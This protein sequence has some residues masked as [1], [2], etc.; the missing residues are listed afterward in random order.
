MV[1]PRAR[2]T[3]G[4]PYKSVRRALECL[5]R[6]GSGDL[7]MNPESGSDSQ[8]LADFRLVKSDNRLAVDDCHRRALKTLVQKFL[9]RGLIG[10]DI[11]LDE[12][13]ALLR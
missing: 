4:R 8:N 13:N 5:I 10:A 11:F 7:L 12:H 3:G 6:S 1:I 9:Q 2:A